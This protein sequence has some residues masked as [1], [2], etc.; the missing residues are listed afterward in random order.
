MSR[1]GR[2]T[3]GATYTLL[4]MISI[5]YLFWETDSGRCNAALP[6]P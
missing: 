1:L 2:H 4:L 5:D 6:V 3:A